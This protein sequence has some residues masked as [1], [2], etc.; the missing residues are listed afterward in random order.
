MLVFLSCQISERITPRVGPSSIKTMRNKQTKIRRNGG[1]Q[2]KERAVAYEF[3][4]LLLL[5]VV[6]CMWDVAKLIGLHGSITAGRLGQSRRVVTF[7]CEIGGL[8]KMPSGNLTARAPSSRK[9]CSR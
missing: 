7:G 6:H 4:R 8:Q 5:V 3:N 1:K 2:R 9:L